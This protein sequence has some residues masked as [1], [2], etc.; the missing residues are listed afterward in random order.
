L[1]NFK[2]VNDVFGHLEGDEALRLTARVIQKELRNTDLAFRFGGDEFMVLLLEAD[3]NE[4][5]RI[6]SRIRA[7]FDRHWADEWNTKPGCPL[8]SLSL[9][10]AEFDQRESPQTLVH[11]ADDNMYVAKKHGIR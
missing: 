9:G 11:R 10:I 2:Q 1:D 3:S 7:S 8:V 4:A 6:G 5:K